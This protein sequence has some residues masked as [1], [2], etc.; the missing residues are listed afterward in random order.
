MTGSRVGDPVAFIESRFNVQMRRVGRTEW[1]GPCPWCGGRDRFHV[2]DNGNYW[3]RPA[4][5]HCGKSGWLDELDSATPP[6]REELLEWRLASLERKQGE[7][8]Q[9]LSLLE[10]MHQCTD[11]EAYHANLNHHPRAVDYWLAE[12]MNP[13]TIHNHRLGYC[14]SC[15]TAPGFASYT[16]PVMFRGKLY[17][18]RHR[19]ANPN[20]GGKYRPHITGLP[21]MIFN[22]DALDRSDSDI[23]LLEGEK[24]ALVV[25]QETGLPAIATMGMQSFKPE[26]ANKLAHFRR[27]YVLYDPDA[28][29]KAR[30]VAGYFQGRGHVAVMPMKADDFFV[31]YGGTKDGFLS[32][33]DKARPVQ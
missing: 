26:W 30:L 33:I 13:H 25:E 9:R 17:N 1:A 8:E 2:W 18:I 15:P 7:M 21:S 4:A 29:D 19:L 11:H 27:V 24:K 6:S 28:T 23:L 3:C 14:S 32:Y 10:Q 12:G 16:I 5:G 20:T 22:A 31:R